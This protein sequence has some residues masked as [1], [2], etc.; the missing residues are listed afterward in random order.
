MHI[1]WFTAPRIKR[2]FGGRTLFDGTR[3][4]VDSG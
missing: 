4:S 3:A 2:N 1:T